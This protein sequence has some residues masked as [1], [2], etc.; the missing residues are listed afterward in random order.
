MVDIIREYFEKIIDY[1]WMYGQSK[2]AI[3]G[4]IMINCDGEGTDVF[5]PVM[6]ELRERHRTIDLF[7]T[8]FPK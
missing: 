3:I 7:D 5:Q 4:G 1:D 2:L 6:F 8:C